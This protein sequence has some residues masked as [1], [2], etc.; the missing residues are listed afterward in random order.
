LDNPKTIESEE[1]DPWSLFIY[2]MKAP[3]TR[4]RY[5]TRLAKF[6]D[7]IGLKVGEKLED[8]ARA[9][10]QR[11]RDDSN[12]TLNNILRFVQ[13]QKDRVDKKEITGA[14]V[15]NY[16]KSIKLFC[17]MADTSI[18]WKK[19]TRGLP[20]GK[21]Y[22]DDRIPTLEEIRRVVEYPDRRIKAIV[23]TMASSGIRIGSWDYLQWGHIRPLEKDGEIIAAKMIVYAGEDDEYFTFISPEALQALKDWIGYRQ[24]SG[25][26]IND[27]TWVMRDLWDTRVAQGRGLVTKPKKLT[28]LGVK[29]LMERAIWAQGLRKKLEPGKKRH[30]YQANHSF[31]K[32]FKTRCEIG[33]MKPINIEKLMNHS[34]GISDSYYRATE[35]EVLE[36]YVKATDLL[37]INDDKLALQKQVVELTEKNKEENYIIKGKL[38][39]REKEIQTMQ[40]KHEQ[41]MKAMR[42]EME[43]KFYQILQKIE[44]SKLK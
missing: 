13:Y 21:K 4:D 28:S 39:E 3:M 22:A 8:R 1:L 42:E 11:G 30:P 9:F 29:R 34:I 44:I 20:K 18:P 24:K 7:Y 33:G 6:F 25:E 40:R 19:I 41:D 17:E 16:V 32:W 31:R 26:L 12:W 2:A 35:N 36:D 5:Q 23:Y 10:A 43:S 38:S 27:D 15:R 37:T 14:T